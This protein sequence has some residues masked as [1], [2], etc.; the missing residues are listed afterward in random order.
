[1]TQNV[2]QIRMPQKLATGIERLVEDGLYK[3]RSEVVI[4]AVRH[5]LGSE[6]KSNVAL[7][8]EEHLIGKSKMVGY[9]KEELDGLWAKVRRGEEWKGRFGKGADEVM[10]TLRSR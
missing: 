9:S 3:N 8:I 5:F 10:I 1:M 4:D 2:V 7:Q 6:R